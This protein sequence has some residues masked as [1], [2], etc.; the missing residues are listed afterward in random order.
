M[1]RAFDLLL[2][3]ALVAGVGLV[4]AHAQTFTSLVSPEPASMFFFGSGLIGIGG[5][6]RRKLRVR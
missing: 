5:Y 6:L 2:L 1:R 4:P 3:V